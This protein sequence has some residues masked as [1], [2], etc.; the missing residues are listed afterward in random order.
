MSGRRRLPPYYGRYS[1][2]TDKEFDKQ[3]NYEMDGSKKTRFHLD[4]LPDRKYVPDIAKITANENSVPPPQQ[5]TLSA[6]IT[7]ENWHAHAL[8]TLELDATATDTL[9]RHRE[10]TRFISV[11]QPGSGSWLDVAP[12]SSLPFA[13]QR[14][15]L[16]T[17]RSCIKTRWYLGGEWGADVGHRARHFGTSFGEVQ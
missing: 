16:A 1:S 17:A 6:I 9:V 11:S 2:K 10:A 5:R 14:S 15:S 7:N 4:S 12:D 8:A 13:R 3:Y